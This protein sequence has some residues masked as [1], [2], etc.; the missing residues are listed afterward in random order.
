VIAEGEATQKAYEEFAEWCE[1]RNRELGFEIKTATAQT[2]EL[3]ATINQAS[4]QQDAFTSEI[5]DLGGSI[6]QNEI[7]LKAASDIRK[8]EKADY[9]AEEKELAETISALE[10]AIGIL[11]KQMSQGGA[12]MLQS[13]GTAGIVQAFDTMVKAFALSSADGKVLSTFVQQQSD[14]D[15]DDAEFGA[16]SAAGYESKS[17]SIV[18]TLEGLLDKAETQMDTIRKEETNRQNNFDMLKQSLLDEVKYAS[19]DKDAKTKALFKAGETKATATG[20]LQVTSK[21]L[22]EDKAS[23]SDTHHECMIKASEF[24]ANVL[25]RGEEMKALAM[26]KKAVVDTVAG[27]T[28]FLQTE[29]DTTSGVMSRLSLAN[30]EAVRFVR[31]LAK[32]TNAPELAQLASRMSTVYRLEEHSSSGDPFAKV[33]ALITDMLAKLEKDAAASADQK[34]WCDKELAESTAK[35]ESSGDEMEGLSTKIDVSVAKSQKLK[36][37]A[38]TLQRELSVLASAQVEADSIRSDEKALFDKN[39]PEIEAGLQGVKLALKILN[40][41][42]SKNE[43]SSSSGAGSGIIGLLEVVESDFTKSL[44][45][46]Q[47]SEDMSGRA[48]DKLT[49]EN[50]I[51]KTMK[52]ADVKYKTK[53]S[54]G[55]DKSVAELKTDREGVQTELDA[56]TDYLA[57]VKQKCTY[58]VTSYA[59]RASRRQAEVAGLKEALQILEN[60]V[61]FVQTSYKLRGV[62]HHHA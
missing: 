5:E 29:L 35:K 61:A 41:Y 37:E 48:H 42:F 23:M 25:A 50:Q 44:A 46:L 55:L 53:E 2:A 34:A 9:G 59:D 33:K 43:D 52:D 12:S 8:T 28:S 14:S 31:D 57:G 18:D 39:K 45:E 17:G 40:E 58:K 7:D 49:Q 1:D 10:R 3:V 62:R 27:A 30:F 11:E 4:S 13:K 19:K 60:E 32:K 6:A 22:A 51:T 56:V 15:D 16:P 36:G 26:A 24:E 54:A 47:A 21:D 20:D 38:A